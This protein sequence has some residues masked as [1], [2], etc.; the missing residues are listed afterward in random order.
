MRALVLQAKCTELFL[1]AGADT[2]VL[3]QDD[4]T[5]LHFAAQLNENATIV[6]LLLKVGAAIDAKV[7]Y[8]PYTIALGSARRQQ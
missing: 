6:D 4:T 2:S 3:A 7:R 5:A 8:W 1:K